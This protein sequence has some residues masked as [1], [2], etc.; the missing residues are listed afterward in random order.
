MMEKA[1]SYLILRLQILMPGQHNKPAERAAT[2]VVAPPAGCY[3]AHTRKAT[4]PLQE[5]W[6]PFC[7]TAFFGFSSNTFC[8]K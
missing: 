6:P 1:R 8:Q 7:Y 2:P 4:R 3:I 5:D